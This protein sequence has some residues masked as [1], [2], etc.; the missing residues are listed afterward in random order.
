MAL[1]VK[2]QKYSDN[3]YIIELTF[4]DTKVSKV[5]IFKIRLVGFGYFGEEFAYL[6]V[7]FFAEFRKL[8]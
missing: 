7:F 1:D 5:V 3:L 6:R 4:F 8:K 2:S